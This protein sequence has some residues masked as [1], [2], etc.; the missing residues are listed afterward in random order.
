M[1]TI[2]FQLFYQHAL[3]MTCIA[4][5]INS[6]DILFHSSSIAV[7]S[8]QIFGWEVA[9]VLFSKMPHMALRSGLDGVNKETTIISE[10]F[11]TWFQ[12]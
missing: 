1:A 3:E 10:I 7:L 11:L 6:S 4:F 2:F 8:E 12:R 9:F 5:K